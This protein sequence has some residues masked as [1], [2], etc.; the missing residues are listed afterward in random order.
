MLRPDVVMYG[1]RPDEGRMQAASAWL[2][3]ADLVIVVGT[4]LQ[5]DPAARLLKK[6]RWGVPTLVIDPGDVPLRGPGVIP[7]REKA[8]TMLPLLAQYAKA[9]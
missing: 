1:D 2:R 5:V 9:P 6:R 8:E 3:E 4:S 7:I